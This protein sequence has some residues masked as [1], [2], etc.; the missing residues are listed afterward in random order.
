MARRTREQMET[1]TREF[2]EEDR[3]MDAIVGGHSRL[4]DIAAAT[5]MGLPTIWGAVRRL[6]LIGYAITDP[7]GRGHVF[8]LPSG[9]ASATM[10]AKRL[11][12]EAGG[13]A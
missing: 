11:A 7:L 4:A 1:D 2:A 6:Q 3:V 5:G 9:K 12:R 10:R 8:P 13:A